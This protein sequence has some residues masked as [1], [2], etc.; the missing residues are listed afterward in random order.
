M[1]AGSRQLPHSG[2]WS[3]LATQVAGS[4]EGAWC[5]FWTMAIGDKEGMVV[6]WQRAA[7]SLRNYGGEQRC[8]GGRPIVL[9]TVST[10]LVH[11]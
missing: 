8:V 11:F 1:A 2:S 7:D 4:R 10:F 9:V 6:T 3:D 5:I